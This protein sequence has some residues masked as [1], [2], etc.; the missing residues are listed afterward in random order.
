MVIW[1][2]SSFLWPLRSWRDRSWRRYLYAPTAVGISLLVL[3][4]ASLF[5][6]AMSIGLGGSATTALLILGSIVVVV[7][8]RP[9]AALNPIQTTY[10]LIIPTAVHSFAMLTG[11]C[12]GIFARQPILAIIELA[13]VSTSLVLHRLTGQNP[14]RSANSAKTDL[15]TNGEEQT[16]TQHI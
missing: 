15:D 11:I 8:S 6:P 13:I 2:F 10:E 4:A 7:F 12:S 9:R 1:S 5:Y 14:S 3:I 16:V